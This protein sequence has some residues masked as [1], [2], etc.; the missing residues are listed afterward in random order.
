MSTYSN[1]TTKPVIISQSNKK[2]EKLQFVFV[3]SCAAW[4]GS[5][6]LWTKS[7]R[8]LKKQGFTVHALKNGVPEH[9]YVQE[10]KDDGIEVKNICILVEF[11]RKLR[12][13]LNLQF[14]YK[15]IK[16]L[17]FFKRK[18]LHQLLKNRLVVIISQGD[19]FDGIGIAKVFLALNLP[20]II[21][22][23]KASDS[24]WP[25]GR[26]RQIMQDVYSKAKFCFFVS[27]HNLSL[28]EAQI[29]FR[30]N[31][32]EV[33]RNPHQAIISEAL[34]YPKIENDTFKIACVGRL[35]I[36]DKG[37]DVLLKVLAQD[38]WQNRNLH[39]SFFGEGVDR[40]HVTFLG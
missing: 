30:L 29:G 16:L 28:T 25:C 9:K 18:N 40:E 1:T 32:A 12:F 2:L 36:L 3:S 26:K 23:H 10:L 4:G 35:W 8:F 38:K 22:S 13:L 19:N 20:Y 34:P 14:V 6:D 21:I 17:K 11:L 7:A 15:S 39:V 33:V 37:Q 31:N 27:Q 24:I 5:E